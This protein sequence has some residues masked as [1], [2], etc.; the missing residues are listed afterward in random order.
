MRQ[1]EL[2][3]GGG[4][5]REVLRE[6]AKGVEAAG[7]ARAR[8]G[9]GEALQEATDRLGAGSAGEPDSEYITVEVVP[10]RDGSEPGGAEAARWREVLS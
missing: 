9:A 7:T 6:G 10:Q 8:A 3:A 4:R 5:R 2:G 1:E